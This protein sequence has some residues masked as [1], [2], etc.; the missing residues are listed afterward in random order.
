MDSFI[1]ICMNIIDLSFVININ[2]ELVI[3]LKYF[4]NLTNIIQ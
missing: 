1:K 3:V 4:K 2:V